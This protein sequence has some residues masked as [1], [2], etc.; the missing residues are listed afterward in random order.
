MTTKSDDSYVGLDLER[1]F[2]RVEGEG[3]REDSS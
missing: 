3:G 2:L 1:A